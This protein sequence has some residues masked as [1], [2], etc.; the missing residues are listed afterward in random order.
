MENSAP[1]LEAL[2]FDVDGTFAWIPKS[3]IDKHSTN[4]LRILNSNGTWSKSE[5]RNL[6]KI[7]GGRER[8]KYYSI[9]QKEGRVLSNS[10]VEEIHNYKNL[11]YQ[12][13]LEKKNRAEVRNK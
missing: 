6:L 1:I 5:Y 8:I 11:I 2:I 3:L 10:F 9:N 13:T 4:R 12:S 7:S